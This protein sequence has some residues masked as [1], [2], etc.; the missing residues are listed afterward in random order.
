MKVSSV[1]GATV[2]GIPTVLFY[3]C[4]NSEETLTLHQN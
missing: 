3:N 2:A 1:S 4:I